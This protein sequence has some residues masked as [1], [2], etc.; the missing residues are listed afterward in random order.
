M[1]A[2]GYHI[3]EFETEL[4]YRKSANNH[5]MFPKHS[6]LTRTKNEEIHDIANLHNFWG[7]NQNIM[8]FLIFSQISV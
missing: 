1:Q 6:N 2:L 5:P 3:V 8:T 4:P 7:N